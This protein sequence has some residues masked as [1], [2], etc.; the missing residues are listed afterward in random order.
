MYVSDVILDKPPP[1][2]FVPSPRSWVSCT[3]G[4][5]LKPIYMRRLR[6]SGF[7]EVDVISDLSYPD[8]EMP[9]LRSLSYVAY[10]P[11]RADPT[12]VPAS[13]RQR[14]SGQDGQGVEDI[15]GRGWASVYP[16]CFADVRYLLKVV[17]PVAGKQAFHD[18]PS[19]FFPASRPVL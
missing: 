5:E 16:K 7:N 14:L 11:S 15:P 18:I 17:A 13:D 1:Q 2:D 3:G 6:N 4:A 10:K 19:V 8:V 9:N 12:S